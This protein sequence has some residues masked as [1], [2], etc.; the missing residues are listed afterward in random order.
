[1]FRFSSHFRM[2]GGH[3]ASDSFPSHPFAKSGGLRGRLHTGH[4]YSN[5]GSKFRTD[6]AANGPKKYSSSIVNQGSA[7]RLNGHKPWQKAMSDTP[8]SLYKKTSAPQ[9]VSKSYNSSRL[10]KQREPDNHVGAYSMNQVKLV[11]CL[12]CRR[13]R[14]VPPSQSPM[15]IQ[16]CE[17]YEMKLVQEGTSTMAK[18]DNY[19]DRLARNL[20]L[21]D[22]QN[23]KPRSNPHKPMNGMTSKLP[24]GANKKGRRQVKTY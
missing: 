18:A 15:F 1:M 14:F 24:K 5:Y 22:F 12:N 6:H 7:N 4:H 3:F 10:K 16:C 8:S 17:V 20:R 11:R 13:T 21:W 23:N 9:L 19:Q 2:T